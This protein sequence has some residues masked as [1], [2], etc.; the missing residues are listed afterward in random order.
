MQYH[1]ENFTLDVDRRELKRGAEAIALWV[2]HA[3]TIDRR[4]MVDR[5]FAYKQVLALARGSGVSDSVPEMQRF[6]RTLFAVGRDA[7][8]R[9][10][11]LEAMELLE[12]ARS[13]RGRRGRGAPDLFIYM[14][15][16]K[17]IGWRFARLLGH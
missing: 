8:H 10:Y 2:L 12:L 3:W 4:A 17:F 16:A 13:V 6:A 7:G 9:G 15:V 1:F 14:H 11:E 5:L